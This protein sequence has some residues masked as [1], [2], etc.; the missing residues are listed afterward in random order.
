MTSKKKAKQ[1]FCK[2]YDCED[3]TDLCHIS[4]LNGYAYFI[5]KICALIAVNIILGL[6]SDSVNKNYWQEVRHEMYKL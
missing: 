1:L 5:A 6:E 4:L 3:N 2:M